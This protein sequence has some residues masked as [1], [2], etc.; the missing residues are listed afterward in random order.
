MQ[1]IVIN[2]TFNIFIT[3][4]DKKVL[5]IEVKL[6]HMSRKLSYYRLILRKVNFDRELFLRELKKACECLSP[7]DKMKLLDWVKHYVK[8]NSILDN[9]V[10]EFAF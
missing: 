1:Y 9:A 2:F 8:G 3:F 10:S 6:L 4:Q 5:Y 7:S